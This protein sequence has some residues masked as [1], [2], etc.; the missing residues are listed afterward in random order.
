MKVIDVCK[1]YN[2]SPS[3]LST[4]KKQKAKLKDT[5]DAGKVL[6]TKRNR[7]S[8]LPNVERALHIWFGEMR[9]KPHAPLLSKQVLI[10]KAT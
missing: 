8:F 1:A 4:W 3:T 2:L 6:D 9:F 5:V 10:E 7:E